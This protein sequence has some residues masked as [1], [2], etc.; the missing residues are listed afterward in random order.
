MAASRDVSREP[1]FAS[2]REA[3]ARARPRDSSETPTDAGRPRGGSSRRRRFSSMSPRGGF[4][5]HARSASL[6]RMG[7]E[8]SSR[9]AR[10]G[11]WIRFRDSCHGGLRGTTTTT[12]TG[13][14]S[15]KK[16]VT[17]GG[18]DRGRG[19][20]IIRRRGGRGGRGGGRGGGGRRRRR[21]DVRA[22]QTHVG[23]CGGVARGVDAP[24]G[25]SAAVRSG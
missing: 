16:H 10:P 21:V 11:D 15:E 3:R 24:L 7:Y 8:T 12:T 22:Q 5:I 14:E 20:R 19:G 25:T 23:G 2:C 4:D 6:P 18:D 1:R 17:R 9:G 13:E